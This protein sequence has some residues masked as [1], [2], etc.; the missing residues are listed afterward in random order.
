MLFADSAS[1]LLLESLLGF[2]PGDDALAS[3]PCHSVPLHL[4]HRRLPVRDRSALRAT[5]TTEQH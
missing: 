2:S 3:Q 1:G 5:P 4:D